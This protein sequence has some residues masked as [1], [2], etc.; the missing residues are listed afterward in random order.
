MWKEGSKVIFQVKVVERNVIAVSNAAVE[1]NLLSSAPAQ[2]P[3][4]LFESPKIFA[5]LESA[6][7][8]MS[9]TAKD[10]M[11]KKVN[12]IFSFEIKN[13]SG[14]IQHWFIDMKKGSV[15]SGAPPSADLVVSVLDSDFVLL[16]S[17]KL[18]PQK[19]FATGKIKVKGNVMLATKL[20]PILLLATAGKAKI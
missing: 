15:G 11:T 7:A 18:N 6:L 16:A 10:G 1:L 9:A 4:S 5:A 14:E 3:K 8:S 13:N 2:T 12:A 20:E 19:A 17:G